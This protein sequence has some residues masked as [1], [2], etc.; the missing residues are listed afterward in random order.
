VVEEQE[1]LMYFDGSSTFHGGGIGVALR[2]PR[3]EHT[4]AYN[5]RFPSSNNKAK[6]EALLVGIKATKRLGVK[7][8]RIFGDF[9]LVIKQVEGIYRVK[10]PSLAFTKLQ[11]KGLWN[12]LLP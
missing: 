10:N 12:T 7:R 9:E 4:F 5:L 1:W 2:S 8:L 6:C 11:C 3:E